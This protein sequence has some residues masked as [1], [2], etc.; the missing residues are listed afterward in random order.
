MPDGSRIGE[1]ARK[2]VAVY[3]DGAGGATYVYIVNGHRHNVHVKGN[4]NANLGEGDERAKYDH[5]TAFHVGQNMTMGEIGRRMGSMQKRIKEAEAGERD[6]RD[7]HLDEKNLMAL[8]NA[9]GA[10]KAHNDYFGSSRPENFVPHKEQAAHAAP[11]T[12]AM[13]GVLHSVRTNNPKLLTK[14]RAV[15]TTSLLKQMSKN[16]T[17]VAQHITGNPEIR[18]DYHAGH[19]VHGAAGHP[20]SQDDFGKLQ[21]SGYFN[22]AVEKLNELGEMFSKPVTPE[23][24]EKINAQYGGVGGHQHSEEAKNSDWYHED[25]DEAKKNFS[26]P[27][28]DVLHHI[29]FESRRKLME[30]G[31][32]MHEAG[33]EA[34]LHVSNVRN[35]LNSM[36]EKRMGENAGLRPS[37]HV[38]DAQAHP[39]HHLA[40]PHGHNHHETLVGL[41]KWRDKA[42]GQLQKHLA[43][44]K[45]E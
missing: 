27:V 35:T 9:Y 45:A 16:M 20:I 2:A 43:K 7:A 24:V 34:S 30:Q 21:E 4:P 23:F 13:T 14:D 22:D 28:S 37:D 32:P 25:I 15:L 26:K 5:S 10:V 12:Q 44:L 18:Y 36:L 42:M 19:L 33:Y 39:D 31:K 38:L 11:I 8:R 41:N 40:L 1:R 29:Y 6:P 3:P 17:K